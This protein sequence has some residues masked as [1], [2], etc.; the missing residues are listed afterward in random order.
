[1]IAHHMRRIVSQLVNSKLDT[2]RIHWRT[3]C[4]LPAD[5]IHD[6]KPV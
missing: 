6:P 2:T 4:G 3:F 5:L 1:M